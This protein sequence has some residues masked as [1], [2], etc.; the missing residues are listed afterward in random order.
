MDD[1]KTFWQCIVRCQAGR[2]TYGVGPSNVR[3]LGDIGMVCHL[4][5]IPVI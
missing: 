2:L 1:A 3:N 5:E 4:K